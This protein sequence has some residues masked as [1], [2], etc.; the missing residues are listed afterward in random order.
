M[1]LNVAGQPTLILN[2]QKAAAD[3]LDRRAAT[4][5]GRPRLIVGHELMCGGLFFAFEPHNERYAYAPDEHDACQMLISARWRRQRRVVHE[6]F[7]KS[8]ASRFHDAEAEDAVRLAL[9]LVQEPNDF[10]ALYHTYACSVVLSVTY[11][12]PLRGG[13]DDD[14]LRARIDDFVK[15]NQDSLQGAH[16]VEFMPWM[17]YLPSW[18]AT[19]KRS[20][21]DLYENTTTFFLGLVEDVENRV[22]RGPTISGSRTR[23]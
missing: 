20:A 4:Y 8:A 1:Y 22:V 19:W 7:N 13:S 18:M 9:A 3:L 14:G 23:R 6:G 10:R 15:R 17:L 12:R 21:L 2:T 5:S 11:D 16:Y